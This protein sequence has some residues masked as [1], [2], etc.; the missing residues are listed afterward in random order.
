MRSLA[1]FLLL[2]QAVAFTPPAFLTRSTPATRA[3]VRCAAARDFAPCARN[4]PVGPGSF[5]AR[6]KIPRGHQHMSPA[7]PPLTAHRPHR[8][9]YQVRMEEGAAPEEV[10]A[11][12]VAE[13]A[14]PAIDAGSVDDFTE[15][16]LDALAADE[17]PWETEQK[18]VLVG[19][20]NPEESLE[21]LPSYGNALT[22]DEMRAKY[23]MH[24]GDTG[25]AQARPDAPRAA[26]SRAPPAR[27]PPPPPP[28]PPPARPPA[29]AP[30]RP[31]APAPPRPP[32]RP[33]PRPPLTPRSGSHNCRCRWRC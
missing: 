11:P 5:P 18:P 26:P 25:S 16:L 22:V 29:P 19:M 3:A 6:P 15:D 4:C 14:A 13:V 7:R 30:A 12:E 8:L 20:D 27:P 23:K 28:P 24:D 1:A 33:P 31:P 21:A 9:P 2:A 32:A 10:A 17:S